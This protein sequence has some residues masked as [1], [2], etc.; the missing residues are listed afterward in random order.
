[1]TPTI[2]ITNDDGADAPGLVA[3]H[4]VLEQLGHV[5]RVAPDRDQSGAGHALTLNHP[6]R[7]KRLS[8][9]VFSVDGTPTDCV[10]LGVFRLLKG[11]RPD[12]VVSGINP[13]S[14]LGDD[15]TYSGTVS[16][17]LEGTLLGAPSFA[18]SLDGEKGPVQFEEATQVAHRIAQRLLQNGVPAGT[19][20]NVNVPLRVREGIRITRQGRRAYSESI[21]QRVDPKG[22]DYYWI[23]GVPPRW[24][25]DP[26]S[27]YA[28]VKAGFISI[29][30][31]RLD[32]TH[33]EVL[34]TLAAEWEE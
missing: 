27:D 14:N 32:L 33:D 2:L 7:I 11:K 23:G 19:W 6:L 15:I 20:L 3:L 13:S 12:L 16:A 29:T 28:A 18:I 10:T 26:A 21:V 34:D 5:I 31:L 17:A 22:R 25:H 9:T 4:Q 1:M 8:E 30:P 24:E